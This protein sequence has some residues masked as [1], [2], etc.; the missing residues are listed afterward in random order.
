LEVARS[1][2][3]EAYLASG[4]G[5]VAMRGTCTGMC[6]AFEM[7]FR[8]YTGEVNPLEAVSARAGK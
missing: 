4:G 1:V 8:E 2:E 7:E 5:Q 3:R 6:A